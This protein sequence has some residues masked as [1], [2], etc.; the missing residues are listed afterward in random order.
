MKRAEKIYS[1]PSLYT[2]IRSDSAGI[3]KG[4]V[5]LRKLE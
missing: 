3:S 4:C 2:A 5:V 1:K